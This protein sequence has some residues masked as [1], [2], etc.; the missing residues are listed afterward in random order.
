M[1]SAARIF[2][3][4]LAL[5]SLAAACAPADASPQGDAHFHW[6]SAAA[7]AN[8]F[9][10]ECRK[11]PDACP[12]ERTIQRDASAAAPALRP[13]SHA[14]ARALRAIPFLSERRFVLLRSARRRN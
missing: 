3:A 7:P 10:A 2:L 12:V 6:E 8:S 11:A 13:V 9:V 4:G 5:L 14:P 1:S